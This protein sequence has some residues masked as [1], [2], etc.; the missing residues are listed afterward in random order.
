M[1]KPLKQNLQ[2]LAQVS[3][4]K[5]ER[6]CVFNGRIP[7]KGDCAPCGNPPFE[8]RMAGTLAAHTLAVAGG[9]DIL[10]VHDIKEAVQ[11]AK[12]TD[13]VLRYSL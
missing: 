8:E 3:R 1:E 2:L 13:A 11:A 6:Y 10:R 12:V 7:Q 9:A 4:R 5:G